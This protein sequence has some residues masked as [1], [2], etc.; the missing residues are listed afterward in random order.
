MILNIHISIYTHVYI[1][2][3]YN[4]LCIYTYI[5]IHLNTYTDLHTH[6]H[7]YT[8]YILPLHRLSALPG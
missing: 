8:E 2:R 4:V 6:N 1:S 5:Y 7:T 3:T